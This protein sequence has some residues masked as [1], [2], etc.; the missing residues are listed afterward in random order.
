WMPIPVVKGEYQEVQ[1]NQWSGNPRVAEQVT[2][3]RYGAGMVYAEFPE[4]EKAPVLEVVSR[5]RTRDR[6]VDWAK[7]TAARL[8]AAEAKKWTQPTDL[9]PTDGIVRET[10]EAIVRGKTSDLDK[11]R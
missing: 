2:D 1:K 7:K 9:V 6:K 4:T 5:F 3:P 11:T 8:D 10:A